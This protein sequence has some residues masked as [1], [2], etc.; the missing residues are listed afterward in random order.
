MIE[1]EKAVSK[2]NQKSDLVKK[3][4]DVLRPPEPPKQSAENVQ[5]VD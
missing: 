1:T 4:L 5:K 3:V 2:L